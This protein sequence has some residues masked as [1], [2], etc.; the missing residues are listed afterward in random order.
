MTQVE[1]SLSSGDLS[2]M[3]TLSRIL[4]KRMCILLYL[5]S[6]SRSIILDYKTGLHLSLMDLCIPVCEHSYGHMIDCDRNWHTH[7]PENSCK[8]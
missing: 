7:T 5:L 4:I 3:H 6:V 8:F 2:L 1:F